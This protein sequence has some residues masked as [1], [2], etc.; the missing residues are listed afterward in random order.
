LADHRRDDRIGSKAAQ[1]ARGE[2]RTA[3]G[4]EDWQKKPAKNRQKDKEARWT[5]KHERSYSGYKNHLGVD[6]RNKFMRRY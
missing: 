5:K 4:P 6:R 3:R 2:P 1:F